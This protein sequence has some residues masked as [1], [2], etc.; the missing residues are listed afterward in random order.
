MQ[1]NYVKKY[2]TCIK[3]L[4][5]VDIIVFTY[6]MITLLHLIIKV[7]NIVNGKTLIKK[8]YLIKY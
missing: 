5:L 6:T 3:I 4:I 7:K 2:M 8:H 1:I